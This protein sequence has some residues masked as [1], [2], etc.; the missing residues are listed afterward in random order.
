MAYTSLP[1]ELT[2]RNLVYPGSVTLELRVTVSLREEFM[3]R[4]KISVLV[5][6]GVKS[7]TTFRVTRASPIR[8]ARSG[9]VGLAWKL[10][11]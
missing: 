10:T 6:G 11:V 5:E 9:A 4:A 3:V 1:A 2:T 7:E 8:D